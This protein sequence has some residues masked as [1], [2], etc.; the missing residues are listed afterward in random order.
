M[1]HSGQR[2]VV[3]GAVK[4]SKQLLEHMISHKANIVGVVAKKTPGMNADF[5]DLS[6]IAEQNGI[7]VLKTN[8]INES[9]VYDFLH[10][11]SPDYLFCLGWSQL[12]KPGI[13]QIA[14]KENIGYHPSKLPFNRGRHPV[15]WALALGLET[16]GSSFFLLRQE[17]DA[18]PLIAQN[19]ISIDYHDDAASLLAKITKKACEQMT[20]ILHQINS[21]APATLPK[22]SAKGNVWRRR[23]PSDGQIDFRMNS[24]TIYNLTRALTKPYVGAHVDLKGKTVKIWQVE[25]TSVDLP[26]IEPGRVL[27]IIGDDIVVKT[28]DGGVTLKRH[29]FLKLPDIG[30]CL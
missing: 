22:N 24:R 6:D 4:F 16:T 7:P 13:L 2:V 26:H 19:E 29:E 5:A 14:R 9:R 28:A 8:D 23:H 15:I 11:T 10:G 25:E 21:G 30:I 3:I 17:A 12:I 1:D 20:S 27:A 18:G